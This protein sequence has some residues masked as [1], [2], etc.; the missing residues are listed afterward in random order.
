[1]SDDRHRDWSAHAE[2]WIR[3]GHQPAAQPRVF[4]LSA[5][6]FDQMVLDRIAAGS[7]TMTFIHHGLRYTGCRAEMDE[8]EGMVRVFP[9][10]P[11]VTVDDAP[12][13]HIGP[14]SDAADAI[15]T[16]AGIDF[17]DYIRETTSAIATS[18]GNDYS[19][20]IRETAAKVDAYLDAEVE[21]DR[22]RRMIAKHLGPAN[23]PGKES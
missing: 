10:E 23:K 7:A 11:G 5:K 6:F 12:A 21:G 13:G 19:D 8:A 18:A 22:L 16:S 2:Q 4:S 9:D 15:A 17:S 3:D 14:R 1:M 20:Y